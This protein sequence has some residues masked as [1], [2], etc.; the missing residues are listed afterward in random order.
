M[1]MGNPRP[2]LRVVAATLA[3][4]A[5]GVALVV[6]CGYLA[7]LAWALVVPRGLPPRPRD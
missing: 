2:I 6:L 4:L 5:L 3:G 1:E 7:L